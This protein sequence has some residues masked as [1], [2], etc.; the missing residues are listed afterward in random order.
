MYCDLISISV[1][2]K[3]NP[4]DYFSRLLSS[5]TKRALLGFLLKHECF[6]DCNAIT[7]NLNPQMIVSVM[8]QHAPDSPGLIIH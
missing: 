4:V 3:N 8:H 6:M 5:P 2:S 1:L 7:Y